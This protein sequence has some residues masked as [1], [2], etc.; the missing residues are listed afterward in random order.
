MKPWTVVAAVLSAAWAPPAAA[1]ETEAP[2][3]FW[4]LVQWQ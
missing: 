1:A 3:R 2:L 4:H